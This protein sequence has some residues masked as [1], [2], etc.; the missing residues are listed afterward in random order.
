MY[1]LICPAQFF[2]ARLARFIYIRLI[3]EI[4]E[5]LLYAAARGVLL[6]IKAARRGANASAG[7]AVR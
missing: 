2:D 7:Q 3:A 6:S 4:V 1:R 5:S